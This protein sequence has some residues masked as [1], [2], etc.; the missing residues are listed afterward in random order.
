M[1]VL[2]SCRGTLLAAMSL[3]V[4]CAALAVPAQAVVLEQKWIAGQQLTYDMTMDG[5]LNLDADSRAPF[6]WAGIPLQAKVGGDGE[7]TLD[8]RA[9]DN[10]GT[11]IVAVRVPRLLLR[12]A[13]ME[14]RAELSIQNGQ[15]SLLFNGIPMNGQPGG[16]G[17]GPDLRALVDP[18]VALRISKM[19]RLEGIVPL[20]QQTSNPDGTRKDDANAEKK[21]SRLGGLFNIEGLLRSA[22]LQALP[23]IWPGREVNVGEPWTVEPQIPLPAHGAGDDAAATPAV[24]MTSLGKFDLVLRG[25]EEVEGRKTHRVAVRGALTLDEHSAALLSEGAGDRSNNGA[26]RGQRLIDASQ[27]VDGDIWFDASAGQIVRAVLK[28][29]TQ[30]RNQ[31]TTRARNN[32]QPRTWNSAQKFAGTLE[33]KLRKGS[34]VFALPTGIEEM[35]RGEAAN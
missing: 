24:Q 23:A 2:K 35:A 22:L 31:G 32:T 34:P 20:K 21:P 30:A 5:T 27:T 29:Q 10:A 26:P 3:A 4:S 13:L 33:M 6:L 11:A 28:L 18:A 8:T 16:A 12:G 15:A 19:G 17:G 14:Q 9:V 7:V 1:K 25:E